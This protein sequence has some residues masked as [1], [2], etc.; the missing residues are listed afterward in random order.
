MTV[1]LYGVDKVLS[2]LKQMDPVVDKEVRGELAKAAGEVTQ[3]A[4]SYVDPQGLS[5]WGNYRG[6]YEPGTIASQIRTT[7]GGRRKRGHI[8]SNY[9]G[10]RNGNAAGAIWETAGR[11][12]QGKNAQGRAFI[13]SITE[14]GGR[15]SRTVWAAVDD[16]AGG[17]AEARIHAALLRA[18]SVVQNRINQPVKGA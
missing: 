3:L 15:P 4:R 5:G 18:M 8:T 1:A 17:D 14:R 13:R 7:R 16:S 11:R 10:V 9:I 2:A 12:S 6:G